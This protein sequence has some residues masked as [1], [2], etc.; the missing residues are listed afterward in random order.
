[1][2]DSPDFP[3]E[4][5]PGRAR[6]DGWT[7]ERQRLF[8]RH[9][10]ETRSVT[11]SA[12]AVGMSRE[13]AYRL[14]SRAGAGSFAAAWDAALAWRPSGEAEPAWLRSRIEPLRVGGKVSGERRSYDRR[15]LANLLRG[16]IARGELDFLR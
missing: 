12:A 14:R 9:L 2:D 3:F 11:R 6:A 4:P 7:A 1:M 16:M 8:V 15:V 13:T 10:A 5:V